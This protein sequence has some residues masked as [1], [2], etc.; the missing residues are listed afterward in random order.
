MQVQEI[1]LKYN[2]KMLLDDAPKI[3]EPSKTVNIFRKY[4]KEEMLYKE[5]VYAIYLSQNLKVKG[6]FKVSEGSIGASIADIRIILGVALKSFSSAII[7]AH[8][9]PSGS[10][11][12]SKADIKLTQELS[13]SCEI[14]N[15]KL[16]DHLI[17]TKNKYKSIINE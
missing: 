6:I 5:S 12:P 17:I 13:K 2:N 16:V 1:K 3:D 15:L 14:M 4:M 7:L 8:N 11:E 10:I 9:H